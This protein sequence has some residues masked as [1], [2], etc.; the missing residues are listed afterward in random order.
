MFKTV[1]AMNWLNDLML[2]FEEIKF[3]PHYEDEDEILW[4]EFEYAEDI[5]RPSPEAKKFALEDVKRFDALGAEERAKYQEEL[6]LC[7]KP[8]ANGVEG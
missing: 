2:E 5:V 6:R 8:C 3:D 4:E 7:L 1:N